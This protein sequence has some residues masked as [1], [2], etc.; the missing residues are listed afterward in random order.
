[1]DPVI[2]SGPGGS[3]FRFYRPHRQCLRGKESGG[4]IMQYEV[5]TT[6]EGKQKKRK[7]R[8]EAYQKKMEK[9]LKNR[10]GTK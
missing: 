5:M 10:K 3:G 7:E 1:M 6:K 9:I 4:K 2:G 8:L